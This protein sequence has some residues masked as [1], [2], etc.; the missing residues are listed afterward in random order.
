DGHQYFSMKLVEGGSLAGY[1]ER[2]PPLREL[3]DILVNV[4]RAVHY[5]HQRGIL[6][7]DLKPSNILLSDTLQGTK[8]NPSA[9]VPRHLSLVTCPWVTD[10]GLAKR[11][12]GDSQLTQ[13]GAVVGTPSYMPPEQARGS[14]KLT[15]AADVYALGAILYEMLT[16]RAPFKGD[17]QLET[18]LQ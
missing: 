4:C 10:F 11:V 17:S 8:D 12:E 3:V 16:G 2:S 14:R 9:I 1:L 15:T 6:H 13:S 18:L 7:R 5:A